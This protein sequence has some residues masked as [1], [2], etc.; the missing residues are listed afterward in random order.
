MKIDQAG[1]MGINSQ[2]MSCKKIHTKWNQ[3]KIGAQAQFK[4]ENGSDPW[5]VGGYWIS[6]GSFLLLFIRKRVPFVSHQTCFAET[7]KQEL[8]FLWFSTL[9]RIFLK[10]NTQ[11]LPL[12]SFLQIDFHR[13][14]TTQ[15]KSSFEDSKRF[16][17]QMNQD[18]SRKL[19]PLLNRRKTRAS[20]ETSKGLCVAAIC[21][22]FRSVSVM[23]LACSFVQLLLLPL[24]DLLQLR[25][26]FGAA[27]FSSD[28]I[29]LTPLVLELVAWKPC[30]EIKNGLCENWSLGDVVDGWWWWWLNADFDVVDARWWRLLEIVV[31]LVVEDGGGVVC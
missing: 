13:K 21:S 27:C 14:G 17:T 18:Q 15:I 6:F 25:S 10:Q 3:H 8:V 7:M 4:V 11:I 16:R 26:P 9:F 28:P 20:T 1:G 29:F 23:N 2:C 22:N 12:Y 19:L 5:F 30:V 31:V 24:S